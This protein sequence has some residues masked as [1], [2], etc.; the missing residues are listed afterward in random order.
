MVDM[1]QT[2]EKTFT[3]GFFIW[4]YLLSLFI[5]PVY[6][7]GPAQAGSA[8][9]AAVQPAASEVKAETTAATVEKDPLWQ[10]AL[11]ASEQ[12]KL[13][14][15]KSAAAVQ[16]ISNSLNEMAA[17]QE[18]AKLSTTQIEAALKQTA[19]ATELAQAQAAQ[20]GQDAML[21]AHKQLNDLLLKV[22]P[23]LQRQSDVIKQ[24]EQT[25]NSATLAHEA[26]GKASGSSQAMTTER[27]QQ[28]TDNQANDTTAKQAQV[29]AASLDEKAR[30]QMLAKKTELEQARAA[31]KKA[32]LKK[33]TDT[34]ALQQAQATEQ[35][36]SAGVVKW[37]AELKQATT[38]LDSAE[39][40]LQELDK[41][42]ARPKQTVAVEAEGVD[43]TTAQPSV[44]TEV[45]ANPT[46]P[47]TETPAEQVEP[48]V[49]PPQAKEEQQATAAAA[50]AQTDIDQ[51][52]SAMQ[53]AR[54]AILQARDSAMQAKTA[55][56]AALNK[57][58]AEHKLAQD[59]LP[60]IITTLDIAT[61]AELSATTNLATAQSAYDA[62]ASAALQVKS[63]FQ[64]AEQHTQSTANA[65]KGAQQALTQAQQHQQQVKTHQSEMA[66]AESQLNEKLAQ[67][68]TDLVT[69]QSGEKTLQA[70]LAQGAEQLKLAAAHIVHVQKLVADMQA[71]NWTLAPPAVE[72]EAMVSLGKQL[73]FDRRLSG[74]GSM[75][76]A[77]CHS[78]MLGWGDGLPLGIGHNGQ[79]LKRASPVIINVAYGKRF[80][81]DGRFPTLEAQA[82]GPITSPLEMNA[83]LD[84]VIKRLQVVTAYQQSFAQLFPK[85]GITAET[86]GRALASFERTL[87]SNT[88][89][90]DKW[91]QG[92]ATALSKEAQDGFRIFVDSRKG[93]C[94]ACHQGGNFSDESFHN[95]GLKSSALADADKGRFAIKPVKSMQ[96]AFK[97]PTLRD[98]T[99]S[100]PYFHDGSATTLPAVIDHY[101][102]GG[103]TKANISRDMKELKLTDEEVQALLVF[104]NS[105]NSPPQAFELPILP[106]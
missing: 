106:M 1:M 7:E 38:A 88:S 40:K 51:A 72:P 45:P 9:Q 80:M 5:S 31:F 13:D 65:L 25:L 84:E 79:T 43:A 75:S 11:L 85:K 81:W 93:N 39:L 105:L 46:T 103:E 52:Q 48:P 86:L 2:R 34:K 10:Q 70:S 19:S 50:R 61:Q 59:A 78:P 47:A 97:T 94:A 96:G 26:A 95:I 58:S 8:Q 36:T 41:L 17:A 56:V 18:Q 16:T 22:A 23:L 33:Q 100:A 4:V 57:A 27:Q 98:L 89:A 60:P 24:S 71:A 74:N 99:K 55:A 28:L 30:A 54:N 35:T 49:T 83:K 73:F 63:D 76:C 12:A 91:L 44:V 64:R 37:Q 66:K 15:A 14:G 42:L 21:G 6:A 101:I 69:L 77:S 90:F 68:K 29:V 92:D 87:I 104:L 3:H 102:K 20:A 67:L 82:L 32:E 53:Q 62:S